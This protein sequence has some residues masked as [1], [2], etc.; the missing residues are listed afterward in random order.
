MERT[1]ELTI[2]LDKNNPCG[3]VIDTCETQTC[4]CNGTWGETEQEQKDQLWNE[5]LSWVY[6]MQEEQEEE[7]SEEESAYYAEMLNEQEDE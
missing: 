2:R 7:G 3:F 4:M 6:L 5:V 1:L